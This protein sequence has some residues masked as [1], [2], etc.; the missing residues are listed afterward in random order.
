M[1]RAARIWHYHVD[2]PKW[3]MLGDYDVFLTPEFFRALV[4]HAGLTAHMDLI[5]G[6]NPHHIV[7]AA[8][9]AFARAL[10]SAI[11]RRSPGARVFR[12]PRVCCDRCG[13][14][15]SQQPQQRG[16]GPGRWRPRGQALGRSDV[17]RKAGRLV[18]PGVGH[19]GQAPATWRSAGLATRSAMSPRRAGRT[20]H[21][22]RPAAPLSRRAR[23]P[24]ARRVW[25]CSPGRVIRFRTELPLPHVGWAEVRPTEQGRRHPVLDSLFPDGSTFFYHVHSYH[26]AE[27]STG[28]A[29]ATGR[30]R[31]RVSRPLSGG[32]TSSACSSTPRNRSRRESRLLA[33]FRRAGTRD[34]RSGS[35]SSM[36]TR[37]GARARRSKSLALR[38][39]AGGRCTGAWEV[40]HGS[41]EEDETPLD[42]ALRELGEET[43]LAPERLYN[44]SRVE[45]FYRHRVDEVAFIPVFAAF[46][47]DAR[48]AA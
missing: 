31:R 33:S 32:K 42:A 14:L 6:D 10:E 19:F 1:S 22:P 28:T 21:L 47:Q 24:L 26:P 35:L 23:K 11:S 40:V 27:L 12:P 41:I 3:Q 25:D 16:P 17:V 20:R 43:G 5:R 9:K 45:T 8:F 37:C 44:L 18:V 29:L 4:Q 48:G 7:E 39:A 2:I 13:G 46:V 30:L 34:R 38:R 36:S 15:R